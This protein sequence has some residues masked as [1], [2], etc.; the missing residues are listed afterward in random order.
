[1][2]D[3][4]IFRYH[5]NRVNPEPELLREAPRPGG[6]PTRSVLGNRRGDAGG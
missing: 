4:L 3:R 5:L 2:E 6:L 1:M